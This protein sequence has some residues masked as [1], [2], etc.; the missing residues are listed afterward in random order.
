VPA[1]QLGKVELVGL[2]GMLL[3]ASVHGQINT[4]G[5]LGAAQGLAGPNFAIPATLGQQAGANLFHSFGQFSVPT[6]GSATFSGPASV[7]NIISRVTGAQASSIDGRLA[8]TIQGANLF[9]INPRG[10]LFGPNAS[11]DLTG[12]FH[13]STANY[14]KLADGTRFEATAMANPILTSAPPAAFGFLG[15]SGSITVQGSRLQVAEG[16]SI[17]LVG[18]PVTLSD[19]SLRTTAGDMRIVG[20]GGAGEVSVAG[21]VSPGTA[22]APAFI[23]R[24]ALATE[25]SN[26]APPGRILIHG[27]QLTLLGSSLDSTNNSPADAPPVALAASDGLTVSASSITSGTGWSGRGADIVLSGENVTVD[28]NSQ[29]GSLTWGDGRGGDVTL[30][31]RNAARIV[32]AAGDPNFT[33]VYSWAFWNGAGGDIRLSGDTVTVQSG[34]VYSYTEGSGK[35]GSIDMR[36]RE[37]GVTSGAWVYTYNWWYTPGHTGDIDIVATQR[38]LS[39]GFDWFGNQSFVFTETLGTGHAGNVRISAPALDVIGGFI[40]SFTYAGGNAGNVRFEGDVVRMLGGNGGVTKIESGA[41]NFTTGDGANVEIRATREFELNGT[42]FPSDWTRIGATTQGS[43]RGGDIIIEAPRILIEDGS[44]FSRTR[45]GTGEQGG[46]TLRGNEVRLQ[47]GAEIASLTE[48][49]RKGSFVLIEA[50]AVDLSD[51]SFIYATTAGSGD[52]GQVTINAER[53][54]MTGASSIQANSNG[55]TGNA[56][57]IVLNA[58]ESFQMADRQ[59]VKTRQTWWRSDDIAWPGGLIAQASGLGSAGRILVRAPSVL[60]DDGRILSTALGSGQGGRVEI[61][62]G[63]LVLR[64]GAQIDA[65]SAEGSSG[66]A[67]SIELIVSGELALSGRSPVDGKFSGLYAQ[68][69]GGGRGGNVTLSATRISI[70]DGGRIEATSTGSGTAGSI[71]ITASDAL[72]LFGGTISS[73][74]LN[75]DGGNIDIRVGNLVHL[76]GSEITTAVGSGAGAGGNIFIDPTFVILENSS[77]TANAFG[78][79][80]G[81]IRI[82]ATYF[83]NTLDSLIDA[84]SQA[85]LPGTVQI[86]SPNTNLSTQLKVLPAAFFDATQLVREACA[87]RGVASGNGGSSLVGVGRGGL[88]ASPERFATSTYFGDA[89]AAAA[90]APAATGLKLATAARARLAA[91]CSG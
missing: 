21:D 13:A 49:D 25:S 40:T 37:V 72:R 17:S 2:G 82:I 86:S 84:S 66:D 83:L 28:H 16:K 55:G 73:E 64:N 53:I 1:G 30:T 54:R 45:F 9:L 32:A 65:R 5:T 77:I 76:K 7:A 79:P 42:G 44:L 59:P 87:S 81:N 4:D 90:S 10:I 67:G 11:L 19:A 39:G 78:G 12:S 34:N 23:Q 71:D 20:V 26:G 48:G 3:C 75:A 69:R 60:L 52:A 50:R 22:L 74:A 91:N 35:G 58:S 56:G 33:N 14:L 27:G 61:Q 62:A 18:G 47:N 31:A 6:G 68:T 57:D 46:I 15:P 89:P 88:A 43:G 36:G 41:S 29:V 63:N 70:I 38:S 85:G 51:T 80:G 24:S 8:S